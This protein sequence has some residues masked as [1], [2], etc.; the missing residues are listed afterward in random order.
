MT[1]GQ[2]HTFTPLAHLVAGDCDAVGV[3]V[4][5]GTTVESVTDGRATM[6]RALTL[7]DDS[8]CLATLVL[9]GQRVRDTR[10]HVGDA[11]AISDAACKAYRAELS[12]HATA[13]SIIEVNPDTPECTRLREECRLE[14]GVHYMRP[15]VLWSLSA[16]MRA[17]EQSGDTPSFYAFAGTIAELQVD[18]Y[19]AC[20][21]C[22]KKWTGQGTS[23]ASCGAASP[24]RLEHYSLRVEA[25][26]VSDEGVSQA[27]LSVFD[28]VAQTL[29]DRPAARY[30][31]L[32]QAAKAAVLDR[33]RAKRYQFIVDAQLTVTFLAPYPDD[34]S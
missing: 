12:L 19:S 2:H 18:V 7:L 1:C 4:G 11:V 34:V 5:A 6:R 3:V 22:Q 14:D 15:L 26:E 20:D 10:V 23:C 31:Q 29:L 32:S 16:I 33:V 9:W 13:K 28:A 17:V 25:V 27:E 24:G 30:A 21:V 8:G